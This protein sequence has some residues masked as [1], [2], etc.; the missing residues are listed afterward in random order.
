MNAGVA[1]VPVVKPERA[2]STAALPRHTLV[3]IAP[4]W[5]AYLLG[6]AS[7]AGAAAALRRWFAA[8]WPLVARRRDPAVTDPD[9]VALGLPLPPAQ[10]KRR[11]AFAV[12]WRAVA[13]CEAP[14]PLARVRERLPQVVAQRLAP[15]DAG[16]LP[17]PP[18]VFGSYAWEAITG[19][20][21]VGSE[22]D[23]DLTVAPTAHAV[24]APL[25]AC[26][27]DWERRSTLRIDAE[28]RFPGQR[29]VAWREWLAA[30]SDDSLVLA[31][32]PVAVELL[33]RGELAASLTA[34]DR[35]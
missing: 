8:D 3:W 32:T 33:R 6:K 4:A 19:M 35:A 13:R 16:T 17:S 7:D 21:Y 30:R 27:A 24:L 12:P 25:L 22:S 31:K 5:H 18:R 1:R 26:L 10:G 2:A 20:P 23:L 29:A 14:W 34:G 28:I 15:L 9:I 11:L